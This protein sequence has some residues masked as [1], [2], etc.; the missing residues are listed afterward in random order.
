MPNAELVQPISTRASADIFGR[1]QRDSLRSRA[2]PSGK[3]DR[4]AEEAGQLPNLMIGSSGAVSAAVAGEDAGCG[5][6]LRADGLRVDLA[7][8]G[9]PGW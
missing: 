7:V 8:I 3:P 9:S 6:G 4:G 1:Q 2:D 5:D